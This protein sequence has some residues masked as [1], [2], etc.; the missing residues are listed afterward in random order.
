MSRVLCDQGLCSTVLLK[1]PPCVLEKQTPGQHISDSLQWAPRTQC[2]G[3]VQG[4][5]CIEAWC[6]RWIVIHQGGP[7]SWAKEE[8]SSHKAFLL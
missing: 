1:L 5:R 7:L 4:S 2:L 6:V 3:T 8:M